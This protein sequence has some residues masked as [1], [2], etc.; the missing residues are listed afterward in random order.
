MLVSDPDIGAQFDVAY[1]NYTTKLV[2][3]SPK[4]KMFFTK[5]ILRLGRKIEKNID[6]GDIAKILETDIEVQCSYYENITIIAHSMGGL[7]DKAYI[8]RKL[9]KDKELRVKLFISLAVP[10]L[11]RNSQ[12]GIFCWNE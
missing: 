12:Y 3:F 4:K 9:K 6:I 8:L 10:H 7:I 1:F 5:I 2:D 11:S